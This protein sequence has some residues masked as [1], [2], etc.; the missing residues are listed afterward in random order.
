[1]DARPRPQLLLG[2]VPSQN[3]P[4]K[5]LNGPVAL[6]ARA[7]TTAHGQADAAALA[8][9]LRRAGMTWA[10]ADAVVETNKHQSEYITDA[11]LGR[12]GFATGEH[13]ALA[14]KL[15]WLLVAT[16]AG[17]C[18][19]CRPSIPK[20]HIDSQRFGAATADASAADAG[21][22]APE[23]EREREREDDLVLCPKRHS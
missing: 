8:A 21:R 6:T 13:L 22:G 15:M 12:P 20:G 17:E 16:A 18:C 14:N 10:A 1:M 2:A 23:R 19:G 5:F 3:C 11:A 4:L 9:G 7:W